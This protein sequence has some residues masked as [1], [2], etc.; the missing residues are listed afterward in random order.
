MQGGFVASPYDKT[1][2]IQAHETWSGFLETSPPTRGTLKRARRDHPL[3]CDAWLCF[4]FNLKFNYSLLVT[5][6]QVNASVRPLRM[7]FQ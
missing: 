2:P 3:G 1:L 5:K 4:M 7:Y 6:S